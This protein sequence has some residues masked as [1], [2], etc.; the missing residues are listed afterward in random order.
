MTNLELIS[1]NQILRALGLR[2]SVLPKVFLLRTNGMAL[3]KT[4]MPLTSDKRAIMPISGVFPIFYFLPRLPAHLII[5]HHKT[6]Q[7]NAI[8]DQMDLI[9]GTPNP[10]LNAGHGF[11]DG[12]NR[13]P[14]QGN[15][16]LNQRGLKK[17]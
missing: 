11:A 2:S 15:A 13:L 7:I 14:Q 8:G 9:L 6:V 3:I 12:N 10:R 1:L 16:F 5:G 4:S 17:P